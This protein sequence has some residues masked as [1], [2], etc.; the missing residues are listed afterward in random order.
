MT[1][2]KILELLDKGEGFTVEFT[3]CFNGLND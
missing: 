3:A 2:D 1:E